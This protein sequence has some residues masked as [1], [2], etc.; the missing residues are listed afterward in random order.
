M[1]KNCLHTSCSF[2]TRQSQSLS[3]HICIVSIGQRSFQR[4]ADLL[5]THRELFFLTKLPQ[6]KTPQTRLE[7]WGVLLISPPPR[8]VQK[9][10]YRRASEEEIA[11]ECHSSALRWGDENGL[12]YWMIRGLQLR[13]R[14]KKPSFGKSSDGNSGFRG[15]R[16]CAAM[17]ALRNNILASQE[18]LFRF[19]TRRWKAEFFISRFSP[20]ICPIP[21]TRGGG[22]KLVDAATMLDLS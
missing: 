12:L 13:F 2:L 10:G 4:L 17:R 20:E 8:S 16:G 9:R 3:I 18:R 15:G 1:S 19:S 14:R 21:A 6:N 22:L 7:S 5:P 11:R